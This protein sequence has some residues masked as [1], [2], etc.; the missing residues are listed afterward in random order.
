MRAK[1]GRQIG[2]RTGIEL[3]T[4]SVLHA[5]V[6]P[7]LT[8][9]AGFF[10]AIG[11]THLA[12]LYVSFMSGNSTRLGVAIAQ[13]DWQTLLPCALVIA[14]FV[15][16]AFVGSLISGTRRRFRL[17][18]I[19]TTEI[20]LLLTAM[21][22]SSRVEGYA[23]LLPVCIA[24]GIQNAGH[25]TIVGVELGKSFIT[26]FLFNLG[27]TLTQLALCRNG[28]A[29]ALAY[30]TSWGA[31]L[32]GVILGSIALA[33]LGLTIAIA[34]ACLLLGVLIIMAICDELSAPAAAEDP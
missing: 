34:A 5:A 25:E 24:M 2:A 4:R 18:A 17:P 13:G 10:D 15:A 19:L 30:G 29:Q 1:S 3:A 16:G 11:Y 32:A 28:A 31:F 6:G 14:S 9:T 8:S 12:G 21:A 22:L 20:L 33:H 26:G 23:A 27:K 7:L